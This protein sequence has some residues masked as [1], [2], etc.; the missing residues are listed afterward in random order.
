M[1]E[2]RNKTLPGTDY[3]AKGNLVGLLFIATDFNT[4]SIP[5]IRLCW[6]A[7]YNSKGAGWLNH[8]NRITSVRVSTWF[9]ITES[10]NPVFFKVSSYID[11]N[12]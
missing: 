12:S 11:I 4:L 10:V 2:G 6:G 1:I 7:L 8:S 9:G 3:G 5:L